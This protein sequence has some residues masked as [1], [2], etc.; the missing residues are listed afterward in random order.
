MLTLNVSSS[1]FA[2]LY[3]KLQYIRGSKNSPLIFES[4]ANSLCISGNFFLEKNNSF[5][6]CYEVI[7]ITMSR[8]NV[9]IELDRVKNFSNI[10]CVHSTTHTHTFTC[11]KWEKNMMKNILKAATQELWR[12]H[13]VNEKHEYSSRCHINIVNVLILQ[14]DF[15]YIWFLIFILE[16]IH[17]TFNISNRNKQMA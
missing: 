4:S 6:F 16:E 13:K 5:N 2:H 7:R 12:S 17:C 10:V 11:G 14:T 3:T 15:V 9:Q 1:N 8:L